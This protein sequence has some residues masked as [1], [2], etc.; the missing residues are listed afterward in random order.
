MKKASLEIKVGIFVFIALAALSW[1][2]IKSGD[3]TMKPGFTVRFLFDAVSGIDRGSPVRLSG[4]PVGDVSDI[5]VI[6]DS[7]GQTKV[8]VLAR[9][10]QGSQIE[11]DAKVHISSLGILGEKYIEITPG[12]SGEKLLSEGSTLMG[13]R[14][15]AF[16][17]VAEAGTQL[18][19]K[20][21]TVADHVNDIVSDPKFKESV[22]GTFGDASIAAKNFT[23]ISE[24]LKETAKSA[25]I[26]M[27]RLRDGEG[28][29]GRLLKDDK[30][31]RDLEAF[32][33][34]IKIH[35]WKLLK[36]D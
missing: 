5:H 7:S 21:N 33:A 3:F 1:L 30:M 31:A 24:D 35:P 4:V 2:V 22:K 16:E 6:R 18:M 25:R 28:T 11:E 27:N 14:P 29:V 17:S 12:T 32:A 20:L 36:R 23:E 10:E 19:N 15:T 9:I 34:E 8:E 13:S 26:V